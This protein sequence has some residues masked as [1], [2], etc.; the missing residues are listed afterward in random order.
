MMTKSDS[1]KPDIQLPKFWV[2]PK[3]LTNK[4]VRLLKQI[5]AAEPTLTL[6]SALRRLMSTVL[7]KA[8]DEPDDD[9]TEH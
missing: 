2:L 8:P 5:H 3:W 6:E 4:E 9:L 1:E 7:F